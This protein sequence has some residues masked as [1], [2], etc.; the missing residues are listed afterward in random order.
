MEVKNCF[1]YF[2][3][4]CVCLYVSKA[5]EG[6]TCEE[7]GEFF[8][9]TQDCSTY[10]V[11]KHGQKLKMDCPDGFKFNLN[12]GICDWPANSDCVEDPKPE[13]PTIEEQC[14]Q[15]P[16]AI[17][18]HPTECQ[19]FYN[20]SIVYGPGPSVFEQHMDECYY[21]DYFN[22]DTLKCDN[23]ENVNCGVR[24]ETFDACSY[25]RAGCPV[26][27]CQ[28]CSIGSCQ[29]FS[30][31]FH[32]NDKRLWTSSYVRCYMGRTIESLTCPLDCNGQTQLFHP[33][34]ELCVPLNLIPEEHLGTMQICNDVQYDGM[35][36]WRTVAASAH[37][38]KFTIGRSLFACIAVD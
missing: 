30:D 1:Y 33:C 37:V 21:T 11:C 35:A 16:T 14:Q 26:A 7:E 17:I 31:G 6:T 34:L 10:F 29:G 3:L 19:L 38:D 8:H 23:F 12:A 4:L 27:P 22:T 5:L 2:M 32:A 13:P 28:P 25:R 36:Y 9:N 15:D 24:I 20:C 18:P